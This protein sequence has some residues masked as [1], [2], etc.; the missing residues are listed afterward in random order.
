MTIEDIALTFVPQLGTRGI[1]H[2]LDVYPDAQSIFA[3][4]ASDLVERAGLRPDVAANIASRKGFDKARSEIEYCRRRGIGVIVSTD[5]E[6]PPQL[7]SI[8][9]F[10]HVLYVS[11]GTDAL[12]SE[13]VLSI[14]GTR[15]MTPYG[16]RACNE[17][18]EAIAA[19][20]PDTVIVSGLAFGT[21]AAAH[22]AALAFG[23]RTVGVVANSLPNIVPAHNSALARDMVSRGGAILSEVSSQ[24]RQNGMLY[25]PRNRIVAG[26]G[27]GLVVV[28]SPV[29][30]G[31]FSTVQAADGYSRTVMAVPGRITDMM[32]SGTNAL[33]RNRTAQLVTSGGDVM[34]ELGWTAP[35]DAVRVRVE[36]RDLTDEEC[37]LLEF[38]PASGEPV[39]ME[40]L[41]ACAGMDIGRTSALLME[42]EISGAVRSLPGNRYEKLI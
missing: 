14:V 6:Y 9:D 32:S 26:L 30:G 17:I 20:F 24:T 36:M 22:R 10:P 23:L 34:R 3:A 2:L 35:E 40:R 27:M 38:F 31:S 33:I 5:R 7:R 16:E 28:E 41:A 25:I 4:S 42:M 15:R 21:D 12:L 39:P 37:R 18:V 1:A 29:G 19:A 11:G 13:H 8:P